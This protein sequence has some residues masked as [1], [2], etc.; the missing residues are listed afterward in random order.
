[1][2]L[3]T[4]PHPGAA[5]RLRSAVEAAATVDT[6]VVV[7]VGS[8][9]RLDGGSW[10]TGVLIG[11]WIDLPTEITRCALVV[12]HG[13][14]GTSWAALAAGIPAVCLP[15]AGD[16]FRN[17]ELLARARVCTVLQPDDTDPT[18]L[19]E[20]IA[21]ALGDRSMAVA[22]QHA[23]QQNAALPGPDELASRLERRAK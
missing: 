6:E 12:H 9:D 3:G 8:R 18:P 1:V 13:G 4:F 5:S 11:D 2:T 19:R 21:R 15:Q 14:A 23:H 7:A 10:E 22:A 20:T 16:Q 17:A